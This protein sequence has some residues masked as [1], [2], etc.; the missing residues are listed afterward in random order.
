MPPH[1]SVS[2]IRFNNILTALGAAVT[3]LQVVSGNIE[4]PFLAHIATTIKSLLI[5]AQT[6]QKNKDDCTRMLEQIHELLYAIIQLHVTSGARGE[7]S[8]NILNNLGKFT[9]ILH[10]ICTFV[11]AQQEKSRIKQFFRQG[12][13]ST[14]LKACTTGLEQSLE[15]FKPQGAHLLSDVTKMQQYA[16]KTHQEVLDL[17]SSHSDRAS[18]DG[19]SSVCITFLGSGQLNNYA[20]V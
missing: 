2:Y 4:T 9:D 16:E 11:E 19:T 13:M 15:A 20:L 7:L 10:K 14:L 1:H 3:T 8:P 17:I 18:S 12:E 5:A 6:V